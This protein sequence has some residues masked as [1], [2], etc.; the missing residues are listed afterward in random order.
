MTKETKITLE[1]LL[2][3]RNYSISVQALSNGS[4]SLDT[5]TY[6]TTRPGTPVIET[7]ESVNSLHTS[8]NVTWKSDVTSRQDEFKIVYMR[9]DQP[10]TSRT[11]KKTKQNWIVLESLWPGECLAE[12]LSFKE[13]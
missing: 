4:P 1:N 6:Q 7:L 9:K 3:G 13:T 2:D 12:L 10:V 11:E 8:V 5:T